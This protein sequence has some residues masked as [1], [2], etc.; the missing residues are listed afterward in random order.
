MKATLAQIA[1]ALG[2]LDDNLELHRKIIRDV[3]AADSDLL[4]FPE[5]SVSGYLLRDHVPHVAMAAT[6]LV[7]ALDGLH[8]GSSPLE[9]VVGFVE[10][11]AGYQCYNSAAHLLL[12]PDQP[13]QLLAVHRKVHLPTYGMFDE[14]RYFV[15]G[16][17]LCAYDTPLLG[18][19]ALLICED[20]W[21]PSCVHLLAV[22]GPHFEGCQTLIGVANSP[23]RGVSDIEHD[24]VSNLEMWRR[25]NRVY[26]ELF[27]LVVLHVQ[28]VGVEDSYIFT[29]GSEIIAPDGELL[30]RAPLFD[31]AIVSAEFDLTE[32]LRWHRSLRPL[33]L[34]E[35]FHVLRQEM[36]RVAHGMYR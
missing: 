29:G 5:L 10:L 8:G 14:L 7:Q 24:T 11:S 9:V 18:R 35:D 27:G 3:W 1:P 2:R 13:P 34:S 25:L 19:T 17:R 33:A 4:V 28:R 12:R 21:F 22:D 6:E 32:H 15:P 36:D 23:A 30:C 26:A 31:E 16:K 20:L